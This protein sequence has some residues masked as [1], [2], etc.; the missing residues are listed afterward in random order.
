MPILQIVWKKTH[1]K[2]H[3]RKQI[4]WQ[5]KWRNI[6]WSILEVVERPCYVYTR[7]VSYNLQTKLRPQFYYRIDKEKCHDETFF[8]LIHGIFSPIYFLQFYNLFSPVPQFIFFFQQM[9][10]LKMHIWSI[11]W[12][13]WNQI[14]T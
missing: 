7:V 13:N 9:I 6:W 5:N 3:K 14:P 8:K 10:Q 4:I 2:T 12:I 11:R 1:L